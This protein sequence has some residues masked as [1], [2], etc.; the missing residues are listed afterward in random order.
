MEYGMS[1]PMFGMLPCSVKAFSLVTVYSNIIKSD[2]GPDDVIWM[3]FSVVWM[4]DLPQYSQ[5]S[6]V[7]TAS[8]VILEVMLHLGVI[9]YGLDACS[10]IASP[11]FKML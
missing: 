1:F 4:F 5:H 8:K 10:A 11:K 2:P 3:T 6:E 9:F 7:Y